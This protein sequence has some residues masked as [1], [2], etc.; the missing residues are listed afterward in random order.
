MHESGL[1]N[2]PI[3]RMQKLK[4]CNVASFIYIRGIRGDYISPL[5]RCCK[6]TA[7][8]VSGK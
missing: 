1:C 6:R 8:Y 4:T 5:N 2:V 7:I 3:A